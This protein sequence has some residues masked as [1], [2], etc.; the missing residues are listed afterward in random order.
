MSRRTKW[1]VQN[2]ARTTIDG[3]AKLITCALSIAFQLVP[4]S[5]SSFPFGI[6]ATG[7]GQDSLIRTLCTSTKHRTQSFQTVFS[8]DHHKQNLTSQNVL[9]KR[10][11]IQQESAESAK[12]ERKL[13]VV[14]SMS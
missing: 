6:K 1:A 5:P 4:F 2:D 13:T 9:S 3:R 12:Q 10:K 11:F 7:A 14:E 8:S